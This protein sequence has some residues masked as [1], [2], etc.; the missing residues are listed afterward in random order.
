MMPDET[1]RVEYQSDIIYQATVP[2]DREK[3]WDNRQVWD[4]LSIKKN[5]IMNGLVV[6]ECALKA[7]EKDQ[8]L[9]EID[10]LSGYDDELEETV[11]N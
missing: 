11:K 2:E 9:Q 3:L 6:I 1:K 8:I 10:K 5:R 7:G 4:A